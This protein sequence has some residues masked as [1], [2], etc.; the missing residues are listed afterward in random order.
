MTD[1]AGG[2]LLLCVRAAVGFVN[3]GING[4]RVVAITSIELALAG[5]LGAGLRAP[6]G[7]VGEVEPPRRIGPPDGPAPDDPAFPEV[8]PTASREPLRLMTSQ[9]RVFSSSVSPALCACAPFAA[10]N[11]SLISIELDMGGGAGPAY[12]LAGF[13][14]GRGGSEGDKTFRFTSGVVSL[15]LGGSA[16]GLLGGTTG[17]PAGAAWAVPPPNG[18]LGFGFDLLVLRPT[19]AALPT[20]AAPAVSELRS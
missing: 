20:A 5:G 13:I 1:I 18:L 17:G 2:E 7:R 12:V 19:P 4:K 14:V 10:R 6:P 3:V 8:E 11:D 9:L 15:C 16:G